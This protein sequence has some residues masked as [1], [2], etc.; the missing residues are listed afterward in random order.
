MTEQVTRV[1]AVTASY[2]RKGRCTRCGKGT[3]R[4]RSFLG[5]SLAEC[6]RLAD[7]WLA[8]PLLHKRCEGQS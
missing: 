4:T 1:D 5:S 6:N 8:T 7:V 2:F 3:E